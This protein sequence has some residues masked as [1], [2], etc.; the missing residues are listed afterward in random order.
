MVYAR[1]NYDYGNRWSISSGQFRGQ[2]NSSPDEMPRT[3][4]LRNSLDLSSY[5]SGTVT[6]NWA[7]T[8][9]G[10]LESTD[11]VYYAFSA[12]GGSTWGNNIESIS[13]YSVTIPDQYLVTDFKMRFYFTYNDPAE[14]VYLDDIR[15]TTELFTDDCGTFNNW[16]SKLLRDALEYHNGEFRGQGSSTATAAQRSLTIN[17]NI[18][19]SLYEPGTVVICWKQDVSNNLE[20]SDV[21]SHRLSRDGGGTWSPYFEALRGNNTNSLFAAVI[22]D[23]YVIDN[24]Q[25]RL[26]FYVNFNNSDEYCLHRQHCRRHHGS[27]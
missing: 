21:L 16:N 18:N 20:S 26:Q 2:G 12:D 15:I 7:Q 3:L 22:P 4:T 6:L 13:P 17:R 9:S 19:L 27:G 14:N 25:F 5:A 11:K 8:S 10:T 23:N 24:T 1:V